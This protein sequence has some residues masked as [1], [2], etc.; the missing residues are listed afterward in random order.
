MNTLVCG[1]GNSSGRVSLGDLIFS[2]LLSFSKFVSAKKD[3]EIDTSNGQL[4]SELVLKRL[5]VW[6]V[7][8]LHG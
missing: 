2:E 8:P 3:N 5:K 7:C 1:A 4:P 6:E